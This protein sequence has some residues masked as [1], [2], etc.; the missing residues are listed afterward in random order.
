[1]L[2]PKTGPAL[3][4]PK[5]LGCLFVAD[6]LLALLRPEFEFGRL[7][8]GRVD[9]E[10]EGGRRLVLVRRRRYHPLQCERVSALQL[11]PFL[12]VLPGMLFCSQRLCVRSPCTGL[13]RG[14]IKTLGRRLF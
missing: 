8:D 5:L 7:E 6:E 14:L 3:V 13:R 1:M 11:P 10:M 9:E 12:H 4:D 2:L